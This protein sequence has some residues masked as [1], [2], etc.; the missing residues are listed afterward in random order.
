MDLSAVLLGLVVFLGTTAVCVILFQ[1]LGFG[2]V[3]GFIVAGILIGP[4]TSG[5]VATRNVHALQEIAELGVVLFM[6]VV[7]LEMRPQKLWSM[8]RQLFGLGSAQ[9]LLNAA[10][11]CGY[12]VLL[13]DLAWECALLAGLALAMSFTAIILSTLEERAGPATRVR[14]CFL[15]SNFGGAKNLAMPCSVKC[16]CSHFLTRKDSGL[17]QSHRAVHR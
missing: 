7:G 8:R 5:P 15:E 1:R 14:C 3:L 17:E 6:F 9:M 16:P 12:L 11:V 2:S 4:H 10:L 13:V